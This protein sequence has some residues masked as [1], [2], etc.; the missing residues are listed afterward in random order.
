[1]TSPVELDRFLAELGGRRA[2]LLELVDSQDPGHTALVDELTELGEQL[3]VA[4][5]E[6]RVQQEE[7]TEARRQLEAVAVQRELLFQSSTRAFVQTDQ[8]GVVQRANRAADQLVRRPTVRQTPRPIATWFQVA[9]RAAVRS[10]IS[11]VTAGREQEGQTRAVIQRSDGATV[12]VQVSVTAAVEPESGRTILQWE[13]VPG[14]EAQSPL[15]LVSDPAEQPPAEHRLLAG[16]AEFATELAEAGSETAILTAILQRATE[17]LD[18]VDAAGILLLDRHGLVDPSA[19][20]DEAALVCDRL[21]SELRQGPAL[22]AL[23]ERATILVADFDAEPRWPQFTARA[24]SVGLYSALSV[25]LGTGEAPLG[26]LTL[27]AE[28]PAAFDDSV[29]FGA[30]MLCVHAGIALRHLRAEQNLRAGMASRQVIGEAMGVLIERHRLTS[31][32]AFERLVRA[33]Q[34]SNIKLR[35]VARIVRETGEDPAQIRSL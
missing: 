29:R 13:L 21:Q 10:L 12:Q 30:S 11:A 27:Y 17:L 3:I 35:E 34:H 25:C 2:R 26:A 31:E 23:D 9:D 6:L 8:R 33:S 18:G 28:R 5:E 22:A 20:T 14:S 32:Q 4:D 16:L 1:V 19:W 24:T 7:L 15:H